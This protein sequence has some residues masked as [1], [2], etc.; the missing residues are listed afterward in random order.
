MIRYFNKTD[1]TD[2][3][4]CDE[5][6]STYM[7]EIPDDGKPYSEVDGEI[8]CLLENSEYIAEKEKEAAEIQA[9]K[10][11]TKR[12]MLIWLFIHKS[13]TEEAIFA[14]I[15]LI[16]NES[17]R[18]LAKVNYSGTNV[19]YYGNSFVPL[20]GQALGLTIDEIKAM[21]DEGKTL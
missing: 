4:F 8:I 5:I 14:A 2:N 15:D 1:G 19:F 7:F 11:I 17:Q 20:I 3:N 6:D 13:K 16:E 12:Q 18:Y 9:Q 10:N 21:F